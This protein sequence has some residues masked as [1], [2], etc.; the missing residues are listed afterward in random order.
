MAAV[1]PEAPK[2]EGEEEESK[3]PAKENV[4]INLDRGCTDWPCLLI[5]IGFCIG[6]FIVAN[7]AMKDGKI[8]RL[9]YGTN[10]RGDTCGDE[11]HGQYQY[12]PNPLFYDKMQTVCLE[13]CPAVSEEIAPIRPYGLVPYISANFT[14]VCNPRLLP[15][16]EDALDPSTLLGAACLTNESLALGTAHIDGETATLQLLYPD[17]GWTKYA[18]VAV[19]AYGTFDLNGI[20][21]TPNCAPLYNTEEI[22]N[23]CIPNVPIDILVEEYV[24]EC[25]DCQELFEQYFDSD[26]LTQVWEDILAA[27]DIIAASPFVAVA[28]AV[29]LVVLLWKCAACAIWTVIALLLGVLCCATYLCWLNW[30]DLQEA[31][32]TEPPLATQE[33]DQENADIWMVFFYIFAAI[34]GIWFCFA[35]MMCKRIRVA[36]ALISLSGECLIDMPLLFAVAPVTFVILIVLFVPWIFFGALLSTAGEYVENEDYGFA[37]YDYNDTLL[38]AGGY[39][40]FGL[41][42]LSEL[43][44][45]ISFMVICYCIAVWFFAPLDEDGDRPLPLCYMTLSLKN[46]LRH[47]LGTAATGSLI[48]AIVRMIRLIFEYIEKKKDE[49]GVADNK[50]VDFIFCVIKSCLYCLEQCVRWCTELV[51]VQTVCTGCWFC[52]GICSAMAVLFDNL[53]FVAVCYFIT[54][55]VMFF[56]KLACAMGTAA[57]CNYWMQQRVPDEMSSAL[58]P[59]ML[60]LFIALLVAHAFFEVYDTTISTMLMCFCEAKTHTGRYN[61]VPKEMEVFIDDL[62]EDQ[63]QD[64]NKTKPEDSADREAAESPKVQDDL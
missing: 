45:A 16:G 51:Y 56:A 3:D 8:N 29:V 47:H 19:P 42:W 20:M 10:W 58:V 54:A 23:R 31:A 46:I 38:Q 41:F 28:V 53:S 59:T 1:A 27:A 60:I 15:Y 35:L 34:S 43:I 24:G 52:P 57:L 13:A 37:E 44:G 48:V 9:K 2:G 36:A 17:G 22:A 39:W 25:E 5:F 63:K 6:M 4:I 21:N 30:K 33:A 11:P 26:G 50:L 40:I 64:A 49:Y 32:D 7:M 18:F 62:K 55:I 12:W 14:C 61:A